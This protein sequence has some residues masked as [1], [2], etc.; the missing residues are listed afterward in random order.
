MFPSELVVA[1]TKLESEGIECRVLD[2]LTVQ[3]YNFLSS[4]V[5]GVK[6]QVLKSDFKKAHTILQQG[7]FIK[8]EESSQLNYLERKLSDPKFYRKFKISLIGFTSI[9]V[10]IVIGLFINLY[11]NKPSDYER[12]IGE[13]WCLDHVVYENEIFYPYT[14]SDKVKIYDS[15]QCKESIIFDSTGIVQFPGFNTT[16]FNHNWIL[17]NDQIRISKIDTL[18]SVFYGTYNYEMSKNEIIM[19]SDSLEIVCLKPKGWALR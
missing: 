18:E 17:A 4:A 14:I 16:T 8:E 1:K 7:G 5:G 6:L 12:L 2:E 19:T 11:V 9:I 13:R 15:G 10:L 3:S